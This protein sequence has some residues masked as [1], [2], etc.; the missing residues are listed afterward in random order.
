[1]ISASDECTETA[2]ELLANVVLRQTLAAPPGTVRL[3]LVDP[4]TH[5]RSLS[6]FLRLRPAL[7]VDDRVAVS[8]RKI[9]ELVAKL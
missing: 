5:G 1:M 2:R 3:A 4:V 7:R 9:E 6:A 8:S